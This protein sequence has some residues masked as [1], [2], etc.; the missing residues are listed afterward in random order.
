MFYRA[1]TKCFDIAHDL[2]R[3]FETSIGKLE[4]CTEMAGSDRSGTTWG[5]SYDERADELVL[6]A[7]G[8]IA[9]LQNY[10][11]VLTTL[12]HNYET[13]DYQADISPSSAPVAPSIPPAR[14]ASTLRSPPSAGGPGAG[15]IDDMLGLV[16][17]IGVPVPD[18][19]SGKLGIA[20]GIWHGLDA[21]HTLGSAIAEI[22][23]S[24][25]DFVDVFS[26]KKRF[27]VHVD[28]QD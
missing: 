3:E 16:D 1:A 15:L 28:G 7:N 17:Q 23:A 9:A 12:G 18:G 22:D 26:G 2:H 20:A 5:S 21:S 13:A 8:I 19:D 27:K 10:G 11:G 14:P 25:G 24:A 6:S 4:S